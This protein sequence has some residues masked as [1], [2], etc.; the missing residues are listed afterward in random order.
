MVLGSR[1]TRLSQQVRPS[2]EYGQYD[3]GTKEMKQ[4][5]GMILGEF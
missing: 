2:D 5:N 3:V 4:I 1:R